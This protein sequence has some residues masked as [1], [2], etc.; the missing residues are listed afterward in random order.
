MGGIVPQHRTALAL[1]ALCGFV[2]VAYLPSFSVPFVFD[3]NPN[4]LFNPLVQPESWSQL[5]ESLV[6]ERDRNRPV[7]K[8][9]FAVNYLVG[10]LDAWNYHAVNLAIHLVNSVILFFLVRIL[11]GSPLSPSPLARNALAFAFAAS[12]VWAVHPVNTQAVTYIVQRIASLATTFYLL[13]LLFYVLW[14]AGNLRGRWAATGFVMAFA[15]GTQTKLIVATLPAAVFLIDIALYSKRLNRG[16][17]YAV[18]GI[19][20]CALLLVAVYALD[21]LTYLTEPSPRRDFSGLE[22]LMTQGRVIWHYLSLLFWP[23]ADRL[24]LDYD[25]TVSRSLFNPATTLLAAIGVLLVSA[26]AL[27]RLRRNVWPAMGWLFFLLALSVES[28]VIL[29]ELVFEHRLYLPSTLMIAGMLAPMFASTVA[30]RHSQ[31][32]NMGVLLLAAVLSWQT[33][34]RNRQWQ[35]LGGL[36]AGDLE[37]GASPFRAALNGGIGYLRAGRTEQA[38]K[39]FRLIEETGTAE[40]ARDKGK[41]AQ[42]MGEVHFRRGEPRKALAKFHDALEYRP[43]WTRSA[44]FAG[45]S[46]VQLGRIAEAH[47]VLAQMQQADPDAVF[48]NSLDAEIR[49]ERDSLQAG[50]DHLKMRLAEPARLGLLDR[51]FLQLHL[52]NLYRQRGDFDAAARSYRRAVDNNPDNW[53]AA[54]ALEA[55]EARD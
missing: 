49:A 19:A 41:V 35:D 17:V 3:D 8:F 12:L 46:L 52:G 18:M 20:A 1:L 30:C 22:R 51:S 34:E 25:F 24:Q 37:R 32:L 10:G 33:L 26:V 7:A 27:W 11:A 6:G 45:M 39:M 28:S 50:I 48:T 5:T 16:H 40:S 31:G 2:I 14:R 44:Y 53:A 15:L 47:D 23:D 54:S 21:Q 13:G 4:I 42:L 29:L 43:G 36:W 38:L 9:S 55:I